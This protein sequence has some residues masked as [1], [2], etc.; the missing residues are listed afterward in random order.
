M[1][2]RFGGCG[3][4][5]GRFRERRYGIQKAGRGRTK[6]ERFLTALGLRV[7]VNAEGSGEFLDE[8]N[9]RL[10]CEMPPVLK[11]IRRQSCRIIAWFALSAT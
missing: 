7:N 6:K 10:V 2:L 9:S 5:D 8:G 3:T 1:V 4:G 11:L